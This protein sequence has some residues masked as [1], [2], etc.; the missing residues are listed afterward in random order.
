MKKS[1]GAHSICFLGGARY[2]NPLDPTAEKKFRALAALGKICVIGFSPDSRPRRFTHQAR[3]YLMPSLPL[4]VLRYLTMFSA[5][6][7]LALWCILRHGA[8]V[9]VAQSP[10][11]GAAAA[12]AKIMA[13]SVGRRVALVV[14]NHA[15]FEV[16]LFLQR[17]VSV[18]GLYRALMGLTARFALGQADVLRAVSGATM[19][20]LKNWAP[21]KPIVQFTAWT[22][23]ETFLEA[24]ERQQPD[25]K[26]NM[27]LFV[28][29][30]I[31][32]KGVHFLLDAFASVS[33]SASEARLVIIGRE[34]NPGYADSLRKQARRL[35][36]DGQVI[37][38]PPMPQAELARCMAQ[39]KALALPSLSEGLG[40]VVF[41]AMATGTPVI[42]SRVDGIPEMIIDGVN[43]FLVPPGDAD[44]LAQ[45]LRWILEHHQEAR[46]MG[47]RA[48]AF[49]QEF[50]STDKYVRHYAQL[51]RLASQTLDR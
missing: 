31:P 11:E 36:L 28:G 49:A 32:M 12:L 42:G 20:Q 38:L 4:P 50:F 51:F 26:R 19:T 7:L 43:G 45:R 5:G 48:R 10:Y 15:D 47:E 44:A 13:R 3:F 33:R 39:A 34:E 35:G 46:T 40:R 6:M 27:L 41:E 24:G 1:M 23:M 29:V 14:E 22:D 17:R 21:G 30:L 18:P 9:L 37:F 16:S 2:S 25:G 8:T